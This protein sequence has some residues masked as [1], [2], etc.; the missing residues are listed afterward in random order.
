MCRRQGQCRER[1]TLGEMCLSFPTQLPSER[2][3]GI[4]RLEIFAAALL[5]AAVPYWWR[6]SG[7]AWLGLSVSSFAQNSG[8]LSSRHSEVG[9]LPGKLWVLRGFTR[10]CKI[11]SI[12]LHSHSLKRELHWYLPNT[13]YHHF[14]FPWR[15]FRWSLMFSFLSRHHPHHH[16]RCCVSGKSVC[17]KTLIA[18]C[19]RTLN[20]DKFMYAAAPLLQNKF[21]LLIN[22]CFFLVSTKTKIYTRGSEP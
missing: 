14:M 6:E 18:L 7:D 12:S 20:Y 4:L 11:W 13:Y 5:S 17:Q 9:P 3:P 15:A 19:V 16:T 2:G 10:G 21:Y 1:H 8:G 22:W